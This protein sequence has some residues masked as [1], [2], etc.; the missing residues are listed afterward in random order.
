MLKGTN[1]PSLGNRN[2]W[3][4]QA[5]KIN[6]SLIDIKTKTDL[7]TQNIQKKNEELQ[8]EMR[9][10]SNA[11]AEHG[12]SVRSLTGPNTAKQRHSQ[13]ITQRALP[14]TLRQRKSIRTGSA[15]GGN[16]KKY[17]VKSKRLQRNKK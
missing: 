1:S 13:N 12:K 17:K 9:A 6:Q 8:N 16:L 3:L 2:E 14:N 11:A 7:L 4:N 5:L 15:G 10:R